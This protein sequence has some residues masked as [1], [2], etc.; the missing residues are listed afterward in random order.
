MR[1]TI[2]LA[3][4]DL[5]PEVLSALTV[6]SHGGVAAPAPVTNQAPWTT[7]APQS[8]PVSGTP[9][10][11]PGSAPSYPQQPPAGVPVS[12]GMPQQT[13]PAQPA[14]QQA[15]PPQQPPV[16]APTS[17]PTYT[18]DQLAVAATQLIDAGRMAE[19]RGLLGQYGVDA[20]TALPH[21]RYGD[22]A[23]ALRSLGARI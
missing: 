14:P 15:A 9:V 17:A 22:F 23:T 5:T 12:S 21:E 18:M 19:V 20:L 6:L 16:G 2:E 3:P 4:A 7:P 10:Q 1:L 13:A 11:Q 8:P